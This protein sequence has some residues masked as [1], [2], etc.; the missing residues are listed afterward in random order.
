MSF[1][2][3][4]A[5]HKTR[6]RKLRQRRS[7]NSVTSDSHMHGNWSHGTRSGRFVRPMTFFSLSEISNDAMI[8]PRHLVWW[9]SLFIFDVQRATCLFFSMA[10]KGNGRIIQI[11]HDH[12]KMHI[13]QTLET[14]C[15]GSLRKFKTAVHV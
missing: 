8:P 7:V 13:N 12:P 2:K 3:A 11:N 6:C 4:E 1:Y 14:R 9:G 5:R 15:V 10:M